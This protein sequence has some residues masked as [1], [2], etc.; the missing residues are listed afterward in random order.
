MRLGLIPAALVAA[1]IGACAPVDTPPAPAAAPQ[2]VSAP[3][4]AQPEIS[5]ETLKT[6]TQ[7][8]SSDEF[9]GR[10][11][12]TP[13]G[14]KTVSYLAQQFD[15]AGL[16]PGNNGSWYQE[17]PLVQV[18]LEGDPDLS[19]TGGK[20]PLSF[21]YKEDMVAVSYRFTPHTE[22]K[23]SDVVFVGY[24]INAPE[25]GWNDY[26]G[27]DVKG[28]TVI[29]LVNDPDYETQGLEGPFE[30]RAMTYYGRWTY[31][32]EEAARQ[33]AA[34]AF[35]VHETEPAAYGWNVV[36]SSWTGPQ[37]YT[38]APANNM[39]ETVVNGW[40]TNEAAQ[41]VMAAAGK[42]L[43]TLTAAAKQKGFK[44]VPLGLKANIAFDNKIERQASRNVIGIL[45]GSER[46][47]EYVIYTAHWDHLGIC[48]PVDGDNICNGAVDNASGTAGLVALAEAFA[49][50]GA[51]DRSIIFLAVTAEESGLLG[52]AYYGANPVY[53]LN[54]TV[55][56]I[57]IDG[58]NLVGETRD[59]V[60]VGRGK[61]ELEDYLERAL[62][63][64]GVALK[65]ESTPEAG[66]YYRSDH[67]SLAKYGVPM[68]Y[69]E[70]GDD[71]VNGGI[72][73]GRAAAEDYRANRYHGPADE[74]DPNWDW[75]GA[76]RDL[77]IYYQV[78]RE[79]AD[80]NEWPNWYPTAEFR[81]IRD[82]SRAGAE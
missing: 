32:F 55:G 52:S 28:K 30:G 45:P 35:I 19:F 62:G 26:A 20:Q 40:L 38:D 81:A 21:D 72:A 77:E 11:P 37:L 66:S 82:K 68:L 16:Q 48:E 47:D 49:K 43:A 78:G 31:K 36:R 22:V 79:L 17:V 54:Q 41:Q 24:G 2:A 18:S 73:A 34:A 71:L 14:E 57:N 5:L 15:K 51:P 63:Q 74:Y 13:G 4:A 59:M 50:A 53:P 23:N 67:F 69:A 33:G 39:D 6:V 64:H 61:S 29:I 8:L 3:P 44:A 80:T 56:G 27:L 7:T 60:V 75:S 12:G 9:Q 10:A 76:L 65:P 25:R 70:S 42:D 58:L 46:P 1:S